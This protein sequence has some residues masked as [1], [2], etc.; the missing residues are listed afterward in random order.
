MEGEGIYWYKNDDFYEGNMKNNLKHG[1]G[2]FNFENGCILI[3][4]WQKG[5]LLNSFLKNLTK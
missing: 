5:K 2:K 1:K 4:E 3:G